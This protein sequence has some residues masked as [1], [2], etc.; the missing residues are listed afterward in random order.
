MHPGELQP[1]ER[2]WYVVVILA[3]GFAVNFLD[4]QIINILGQSIKEEMRISDAQ[5]GLLTGT[6]FAIFYSL[7]GVPIARLADR[8]HRVNLVTAA[9]VV[10]SGFTMLCGFAQSYLHLFAMRVGVGIGEAGGTPPSQSLISDCVPPHRRA[11]A[12]SVFNAGV[13]FGSFLGFLIGGYVSD[14]F[15]WRV[16]FLVA[17]VP[18]LVLAL[19][20]KTTVSE[21]LR[22]AVEMAQRGANDLPRLSEALRQLWAL[23]S[24]VALAVGSTFGIFTIYVS[25]AWLPPMFIRVHG[26]SAHEIGQ[27]LA[28]AAGL[29]GGLGT[30]GSGV[31]ATAL[32]KRW[33]HGDMW[34]VIVAMTLVCPTLLITALSDNI[35][36]ALTG[37]GLLYTLMYVWMGPMSARIQEIVPVRTRALAVGLMLFQSSV[38][39][40][41]FGPPLVGWLS[42]LLAP[43]Y[44]N[45]SLRV[46]LAAASS[47]GLLAAATYFIAMCYL[48][49]DL[50]R[51][52][53]A[54]SSRAV[55]RR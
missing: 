38:T 47:A 6:A 44:G 53:V 46:A 2:Y 39:A 12:F 42:D 29:G 1:R 40:L 9:L 17:G 36:V 48:G 4:R 50:R 51:L 21:P 54:A 16:A 52:E 11:L 25:G 32:R 26:F 45:H 55:A 33:Q 13:P 19:L 15:G 20:L 23:R 27:W 3:L 43:Q 22:G 30:L 28:L 34:L 14:W 35:A 49:R 31:L 7:L 18:G 24:Y 37:M 5:L 41:A 8:V 10:W